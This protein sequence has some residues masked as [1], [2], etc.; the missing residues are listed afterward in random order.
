MFAK[1]II[2]S[3]VFLDMP[4]STQ[5]LYFHL[6]MR[7]DDDGFVNNPKKIMRM[8]GAGQNE[9]ELLLAKRYLLSFES[10]IVVIKHWRIHNYIQKD[11]YNETKYLDE[12][13]TLTIQDNRAYTEIDGMYPECIQNGDTGKV[14]LDKVSIGE[15]REDPPI[16]HLISESINHWNTGILPKCRYTVMTLPNINIVSSRIAVF[17]LEEVKK[18][19]DNLRKFWMK[20]D[21]KFRPAS[22]QNFVERSIERWTDEAK[23]WERYDEDPDKLPPLK[24]SPLLKDL[25]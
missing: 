24:T 20:E 1:T 10:G 7:A 2:D 22:F 8:I 4:L 14:R 13:A 12:K 18:A 23:P 3:D 25:P 19:I 5:A 16:S 9:L 15:E 17:S 6:S 11:R 21:P